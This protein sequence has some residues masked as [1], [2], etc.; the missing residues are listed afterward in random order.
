MH[1]RVLTYNIHKCIGGLDRRCDPSRIAETIAHYAAD[2]VLLQEAQRP[3]DD[4]AAGDQVEYLA[5][6]LGYRHVA[7]FPNV[8]R[9]RGRYG[10]AVLSRFPITRVNHIDLTLPLKKRRSV[11]HARIRLRFPSGH[12]RTLNVYNLHLGLSG[13]ERR[14]QLKRFLSSHPFA[15]LHARAPLVVGGDFNDVWGS[16]GKR[17]LEPAGFRGAPQRLFTFPAFAP[18][19]ALDAFYVRGD[20]RISHVQRAHAGVARRASD[21]LPLIADLSLQA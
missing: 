5:Q 17:V 2:I 8:A 11:V 21:H 14:F 12:A 1:V 10:N 18:L 6:T 4:G 15:H 16:L 7:Y 9:R 20:V 3:H 19:R 13:I